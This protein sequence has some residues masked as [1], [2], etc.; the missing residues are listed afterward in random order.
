MENEIIPIQNIIYELRGQKVMLD[1]DLANLYEVEVKALN[2]TVKRN[3]RRFPDD[4]MFQL[5]A[6]EWDNLKRQFGTSSLRYHFG[7]AKMVEKIRYNPYV[8]TEQGIAML[9]G[10][11]NSEIAINV[12]IQ[13]MRTFNKLRQY[14]ISQSNTTEQITELR[15][16]LMLHIENTDYKF[17][18]HDKAIRQI[19]QAL[20]NL[21]EKPKETKT[22]GFR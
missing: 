21:I 3:I 6:D 4:F 1:S 14:V 12:N 19:L 11:L 7:T 8:F 16:L 2:R 15:K 9:S 5:S 17:S 13:I 10:L 18:E 20:N 22:I